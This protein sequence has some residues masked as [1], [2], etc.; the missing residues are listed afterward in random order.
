LMTYWFC[1]KRY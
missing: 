1:R